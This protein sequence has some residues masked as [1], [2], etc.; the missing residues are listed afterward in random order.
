ML[1]TIKQFSEQFE[2]PIYTC[3][4]HI[5]DG[6]LPHQKVGSTYLIDSE[7]LTE[8]RK[9]LEQLEIKKIEKGGRPNSINFNKLKNSL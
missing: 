4:Q 1:L 8:Y 2:I 3:Y 6:I 9:N 7:L 5:E